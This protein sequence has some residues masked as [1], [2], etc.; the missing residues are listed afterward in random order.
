MRFT[1][2]R[3][4]VA[5]RTA[6]RGARAVVGGAATDSPRGGE[7]LWGRFRVRGGTIPE[8]IS[9]NISQIFVVLVH[10]RTCFSRVRALRVPVLFVRL[11]LL[12]HYVSVHEFLS[13]Q[14]QRASACVSEPCSATHCSFIAHSFVPCSEHKPHAECNF[15]GLHCIW[16]GNIRDLC[17][18]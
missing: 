15:W 3:A 5:V 2:P 13:F 18:G 6:R 12:L 7:V 14:L 10:A 9:A 17:S 4:R 11:C 8:D 16:Y 1:P